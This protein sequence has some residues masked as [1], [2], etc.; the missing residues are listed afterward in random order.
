MPMDLEALLPRLLPSAIDWVKAQSASILDCGSPLTDVENRLAVAVGVAR[1]E[2][3]RLQTVESL[4][5]P[6]DPE[7][8]HVAIETGLLGP[9]MIGVTFGHGIYVRD[10][11]VTNRLISHECRHVFQYEQ[12]GSIDAFLPIYLQQIATVGYRDAPFEIDAR[13]HELD[14]P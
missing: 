4:P 2:R 12:A 11:Y 6:D 7:L 8:R 14:A 1:P 10:G 3:V 5:L 9:G 13:Q